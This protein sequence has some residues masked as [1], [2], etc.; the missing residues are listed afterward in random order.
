MDIRQLRLFCRIVE[1]HSFSLAAGDVHIT[2]PAASLQVR[3]LERELKTKLLDRSS[4]EIIPTDSGEVLYRY[5]KQILDLHERAGT[6]IAN[7]GDIAGGRSAS[8][9]R[10]ARASTSCRPSWLVSMSSIRR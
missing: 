1:R 5:A 10:P 9:R 6:E 8:A 7:L 2:Q 3:S 4:R